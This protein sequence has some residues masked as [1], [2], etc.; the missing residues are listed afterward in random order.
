MRMGKTTQLEGATLRAEAYLGY[1][2]L[3]KTIGETAKFFNVSVDI[4]DKYLCAYR[5]GSIHATKG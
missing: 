2:N 4:I 3:G 5:L 1:M